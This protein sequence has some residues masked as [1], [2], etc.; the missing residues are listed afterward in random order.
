MLFHEFQIMI[1]FVC[2][3]KSNIESIN[4]KIFHSND[5]LNTI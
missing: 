3:E 4:Y 1:I 2:N 5:I